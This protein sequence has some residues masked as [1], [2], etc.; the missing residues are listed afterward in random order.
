MSAAKLHSHCLPITVPTSE[1][2]HTG[3][4]LVQ[5]LLYKLC[6]GKGHEFA[7]TATHPL[8]LC[9]LLLHNTLHRMSKGSLHPPS[10]SP[11]HHCAKPAC[12]RGRGG[13]HDHICKS[14]RPSDALLEKFNKV[15]LIDDF[16]ELYTTSLQYSNSQ[17]ESLLIIVSWSTDFFNG[18]WGGLVRLTVHSGQKAKGRHTRAHVSCTYI[19]HMWSYTYSLIL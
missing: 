9:V 8:P 3:A 6:W 4:P 7:I 2:L 19:T 10:S 11:Q 13:R 1:I 16:R 18:A 17:K 12:K 14:C 5:K 15:L